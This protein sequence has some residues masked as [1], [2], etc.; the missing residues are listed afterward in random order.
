V[1]LVRLAALEVAHWA[2]VREAKQSRIIFAVVRS[3]VRRV[4]KQAK[5]LQTID[6]FAV[7]EHCGLNFPTPAEVESVCANFASNFRETKY[8]RVKANQASNHVEQQVVDGVGVASSKKRRIT[9][10][11]PVKKASRAAVKVATS[12]NPV[13]NMCMEGKTDGAEEER[14]RRYFADAEARCDA[15]LMA[16][17]AGRNIPHVVPKDEMPQQPQTIPASS[18]L[19]VRCMGTN[20]SECDGAHEFWVALC[21]EDVDCRR[22]SKIRIQWLEAAGD[23]RSAYTEDTRYKRGLTQRLNVMTILCVLR[24]RLGADVSNG[25][26]VK[27]TVQEYAKAML[28]AKTANQLF[29]AAGARITGSASARSKRVSRPVARAEGFVDPTMPGVSFA[30]P[31]GGVARTHRGP[32]LQ[33]PQQPQQQRLGSG[34]P[35][36]TRSWV[37]ATKRRRVGSAQWAAAADKKP[38]RDSATPSHIAGITQGTSS[39][40]CQLH[41]RAPPRPTPRRR[42]IPRDL[43]AAKHTDNELRLRR[44]LR[45]S[46][47]VRSVQLLRRKEIFVRRSRNL[48]VQATVVGIDMRHG[49]RR[50]RVKVAGNVSSQ[51][52]EW[53]DARL[54]VGSVELL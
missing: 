7:C 35:A 50:T 33:Q 23:S 1:I 31:K 22:Q 45:R 27:L 6:R 38:G 44:C 14:M 21:L 9:S 52:F 18:L 28:A 19:A 20:S 53:V 3:L 2:K 51:R 39:Q 16:Q 54:L 30:Q 37:P 41:K 34:A 12:V 29:D 15:A 42:S 13:G 46:D 47:F 49:V 40:Q 4:E 36:I 24:S 17:S 8:R 48:Y 43:E 5:H 25:T 10:A 32:Q 11:A 26:A